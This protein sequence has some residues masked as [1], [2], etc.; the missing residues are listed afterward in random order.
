[1]TSFK[2]SVP[3]YLT[4][5]K[6]T[7]IQIVFTAIFAFIFIVIYRPFGY[8]KWYGN[9]GNMELLAGTS[10]V[11][12]LGM[13]LIIITRI[14]MFFMKKT[15]E[16]TLAFYIW[17]IAAEIFLLGG[18]YTALEVFIL[19]DVRSPLNLFIN[20]VENTSLI[21]LIPYTLSI[22]FFAWKDIKRKLDQVVQQFRDPSEIFIPIK[23][24]KGVLRLTLKSMNILYLESDDNYV[25]VY[26]LDNDKTKTYL[27]RNSLKQ[28]EKNLKEYPIYRCHR[29]Y[30][31]NIK[32][33]K[34]IRKAKKGYELII[35]SQKGECLPVSKSYEK[36]IL[37]LLNLK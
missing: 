14:A 15:H 27:V 29:S 20:A 11:V 32:N 37:D 16:I 7:I 21:L 34:M 3:D 9:I 18:F 36:K 6:N 33:V 12:I 10:F 28:L 25:N 23:D 35:N 22:L 31:V 13:V 5:R 1:M 19:D 8:D 17:M 26:Y 24:E 2:Q 4:S 30:S